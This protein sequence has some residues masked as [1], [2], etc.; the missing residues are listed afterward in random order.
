MNSISLGIYD[1][2]DNVTNYAPLLERDSGFIRE[3]F[4][5]N[6]QQ[7]WTAPHAITQCSAVNRSM[8]AE[9]PVDQN[10]SV[11]LDY[12]FSQPS[13]VTSPTGTTWLGTYAPAALFY[14]SL[15][16]MYTYTKGE[17]DM[18]TIVAQEVSNSMQGLKLL[19]EGRQQSDTFFRPTT[20]VKT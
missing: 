5:S 6:A 4:P 18:I 13:I 16:E 1:P 14:C 11:T 3:A 10:Y 7:Y 12:D 9:L 8:L 19:G 15:Q 17:T 20:K 2:V